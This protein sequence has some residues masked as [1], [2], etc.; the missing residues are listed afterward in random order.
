MPATLVCHKGGGYS[1]TYDPDDPLPQEDN[2]TSGTI[3]NEKGKKSTIV[4]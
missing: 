2:S 3:S 4:Y 1:R